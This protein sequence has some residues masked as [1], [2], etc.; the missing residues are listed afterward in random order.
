M[1]S[2][3]RKLSIPNY[4]IRKKS[5]YNYSLKK[6]YVNFTKLI[7]FI[8]TGRSIETNQM[9]DNAIKH[10][11]HTHTNNVLQHLETATLHTFFGDNNNYIGKIWPISSMYVNLYNISDLKAARN[12]EFI[13]LE[14]RGPNDNPLKIPMEFVDDIVKCPTIVSN[15][16]PNLFT[17][18]ERDLLF[19]NKIADMISNTY[20]T[21]MYRE[22]ITNLPD[23]YPLA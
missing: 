9:I 13:I 18:I 19:T 17:N 3:N 5:A 15:W 8:R 10:F 11:N 20:T 4:S 12:G 23:S 14:V 1:H 6:N 22:T 2:Y 16:R 21:F 7:G